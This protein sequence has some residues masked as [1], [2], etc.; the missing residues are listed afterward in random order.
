VPTPPAAHNILY[1]MS[2]N[3]NVVDN[4]RRQNE[5]ALFLCLSCIILR[6]E[7]YDTRLK[8]LYYTSLDNIILYTVLCTVM[9]V[10]SL[11]LIRCN[12]CVMKTET[13]YYHIQLY[14]IPI[15]ILLFG[16]RNGDL[17]AC[18]GVFALKQ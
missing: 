3:G 15:Y 11:N 2:S 14:D 9:D 4:A 8:L 1:I 13:V 5:C 7:R 12:Y 16:R 17:G 18:K 6:Y 10:I